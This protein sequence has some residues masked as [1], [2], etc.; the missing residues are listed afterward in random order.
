[1]QCLAEL[2]Y[3]LS[4]RIPQAFDINGF[5]EAIPNS[6]LE[7]KELAHLM[8]GKILLATNVPAEL[9]QLYL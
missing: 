9:G 2:S 4:R 5:Q 6:I 8:L 7:L 3:Y 1:M